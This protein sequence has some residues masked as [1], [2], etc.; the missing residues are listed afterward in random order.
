MKQWLS[1][2]ALIYSM[3]MNLC[4]SY[5]YSQGICSHWRPKTIPRWY[6]RFTAEKWRHDCVCVWRVQQMLVVSADRR[7]F[8][9]L[10]V[11]TSLL[12]A[13]LSALITR[14]H[15]TLLFARVRSFHRLLILQCNDSGSRP[16]LLLRL[17]CLDWDEDRRLLNRPVSTYSDIYCTV[18]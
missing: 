3:S 5:W 1:T 13:Q 7:L 11:P 6:N 17:C 12:S 15:S 10:S 18:T 8:R 4:L 14:L 9:H 16:L 2:I